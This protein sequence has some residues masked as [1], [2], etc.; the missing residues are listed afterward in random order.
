MEAAGKD[1]RA[2]RTG[3]LKGRRGFERGPMHALAY[4]HR[5]KPICC[6]RIR[7]TGTR[8]TME[9]TLQH[10]KRTDAAHSML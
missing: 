2:W 10:Q 5:G 3:W 8:A 4:R 7:F 6:A 9:R 1:S